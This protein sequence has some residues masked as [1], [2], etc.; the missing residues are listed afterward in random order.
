MSDTNTGKPLVVAC[1]PAYNEEKTIAAVIIKAQKH[2][3]K[4]IV[5]DDGSN[6]LTGEI[7]K[8]MGAEVLTHERN[9]GKGEAMKTLLR[10][11]L[12]LGADII[13]TLDADGQ[14]DPD[15]I[16]KLVDPILKGEADVTIGSRFVPGA[17][18]DMPRYRLLGTLLIN[19]L[20]R[21]RVRTEVRDI[22]SGFRTFTRRA[23]EA[24]LKAEAKGYS[25]E[26]EQLFLVAQAGLRIVEVPV[27][28]RYRGLQ[29]SKKR[30][31]LHGGELISHTLRLIVEQ[32][33]LLLL[34]VP[35]LFL[36]LLGIVSVA[37]LVWNF[38]TTRFFSIPLAIAA[39]GAFISGL[40]LMTTAMTLYALVRLAERIKGR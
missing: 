34:G 18:T 36:L 28:I 22:Q 12:E 35:G 40:L 30:P 6:D 14:H 2:V 27:S 20:A 37:L 4:V 13:V 24:A 10:R 38:N 32:R 21:K 8:R 19:W 26:Q 25:I 11:A 33:P 39:V 15:E 9:K 3:D 23:A 5:C 7:A 31:L 17:L 16:P 1:I 29:T